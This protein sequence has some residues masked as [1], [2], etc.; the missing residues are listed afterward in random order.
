MK[1]ILIFLLLLISNNL[2][3]QIVVKTYSNDHTLIS[4]I[5][6]ETSIE[7]N[8]YL[9]KKDI[10]KIIKFNVYDGD[11]KI[12]MSNYE[13]KKNKFY[14]NIWDCNLVDSN[15]NKFKMLLLIYEDEDEDQIKMI[16][17]LYKDK[18]IIFTGNLTY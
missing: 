9:N 1:K 13:I 16:T 7:I 11:E 2:F 18:Y 6:T 3:T 10:A 17:F 14:G 15:N 8:L 12:A 4:K 5:E